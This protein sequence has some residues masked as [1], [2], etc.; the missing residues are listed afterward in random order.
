MAFQ[1]HLNH[2]PIIGKLTFLDRNSQAQKFNIIE[3]KEQIHIGRLHHLPYPGD[4]I[5]VYS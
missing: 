5:I 3:T 4:M 2:L 1:S